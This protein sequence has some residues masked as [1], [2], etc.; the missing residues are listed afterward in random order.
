[1]L[2]GVLDLLL[3]RTNLSLLEVLVATYSILADCT[4]SG[5]VESYTENDF[6]RIAQSGIDYSFTIEHSRNDSST[7][8][9]V[10]RA[11]TRMLRR[12]PVLSVYAGDPRC[13][14]SVAQMTR[15]RSLTG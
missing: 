7:R 6:P 13:P 11:N 4:Q 10:L 3:R 12:L 2:L 15:F 5:L 14:S 9:K 1:M 8:Q